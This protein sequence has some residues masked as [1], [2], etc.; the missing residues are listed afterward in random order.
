[1]WRMKFWWLV[2]RAPFPRW[3]TSSEEKGVPEALPPPDALTDVNL[4]SPL[5]RKDSLV[6]KTKLGGC[7][8]VSHSRSP[9]CTLQAWAANPGLQLP[10]SHTDHHHC[11]FTATPPVTD[12]DRISASWCP[13]PPCC[14]PGSPSWEEAWSSYNGSFHFLFSDFTVYLQHPARIRPYSF[15]ISTPKIANWIKSCGKLDF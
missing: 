3:R 11:W 5:G 7:M 12:K 14:G 13:S 4:F 9:Q 2:H 10:R 15:F 1:M 8:E 6:Q